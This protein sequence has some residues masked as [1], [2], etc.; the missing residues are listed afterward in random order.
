MKLLDL[1]NYLSLERYENTLISEDRIEQFFESVSDYGGPKSTEKILGKVWKNVFGKF[2]TNVFE[3]IDNRS[4]PEL[5]KSYEEYY[6][7][8]I[9]DGA[10]AGKGLENYR[11]KFEYSKR[12]FSRLKHLAKHLELQHDNCDNFEKDYFIEIFKKV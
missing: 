6:V 5:A 7:N 8:G 11:K 1:K 2:G 12:N 9:S 3:L 4:I 10:C